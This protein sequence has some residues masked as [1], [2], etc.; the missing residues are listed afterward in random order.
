MKIR[1]AFVKL[2]SG[3]GLVPSEELNILLKQISD[4]QVAMRTVI[5][6]RDG[7]VKALEGYAEKESV[8]IRADLLDF[9]KRIAGENLTHEELASELKKNLIKPLEEIYE[10]IPEL[11]EPTNALQ[12]ATKEFNR[13]EK[14]MKSVRAQHEVL[15]EKAKT[16]LEAGQKIPV[17]EAELQGV[18][19]E[20]KA[21]KETKDNAERDL[22]MA[23]ER[24]ENFKRINIGNA[25]SN[26]T[27][28]FCEFLD[29]N[30]TIWSCPKGSS[31]VNISSASE[32]TAV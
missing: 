31:R 21:A 30:G 25:I 27:N 20:F 23:Q 5:A 11:D 6:E 26:M 10:K 1:N 29:R 16:D 2:A 18:A 12:N 4:L 9:S 3:L 19:I 28:A 24:L 32:E 15:L 13:T 22:Q 14:K 8:Q 7:L 17:S